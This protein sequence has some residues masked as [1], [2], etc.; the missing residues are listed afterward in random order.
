MIGVM[1]G[2]TLTMNNALYESSQ[3]ANTVSN[4]A[5][6]SDIIGQDATM[7]LTFSSLNA[8]SLSFSGDLDGDGL[9]ETVLYTTTQD[10]TT[11]L[12]KLYRTVSNQNG[13]QPLLVGTSLIS[14]TFKY[15]DV[16]R[17]ITAVPAN[18]TAV[19]VILVASVPGVSTQGFT[20]A[21][22]DFKVYPVNLN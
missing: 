22:N 7:A 2:M 19:R 9:N 12:Y 1:L 10:P 13:G 4:V 8:N 15:Y 17:Y 5:S 11:K 20:T 18:V 21:T 3:R 6:T 16:N 14:V